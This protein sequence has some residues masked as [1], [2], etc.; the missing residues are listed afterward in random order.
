MKKNKFLPIVSILSLIIILVGSTFSYFAATASS[1]S[2][3][4]G[5]TAL[6]FNTSV[7]ITALYNDKALIPMDDTDV[8]TGYSHNCVDD[9][10][11]GACQAYNINVSNAGDTTS[12]DGS[13]TFNVTGIDNLKYLVLDEDENEYVGATQIVSGNDQTLGDGFSLGANESKDFILIIWLSNLSGPQDDDDANGSYS[14]SVTYQAVGGSRIT[15]T[16]SSH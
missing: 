10:G 9:H 7:E 3:A 14:A 15:G 5:F 4:I 11:Y 8:M 6:G 12:Y 1:N 2:D 13:I 16:F